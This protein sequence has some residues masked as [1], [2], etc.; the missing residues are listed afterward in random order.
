MAERK[1]FICDY[2]DTYHLRPGHPEESEV[3]AVRRFRRDGNLFGIVFE[4]NTF[5]A[6]ANMGEYEDEYDFIIGSTGAGGIAMLPLDG[7]RRAHT[8][9]FTDTVNQYYACELYDLFVSVG[10][11]VVSVDV[12]GFAGGHSVGDMLRSQ[13][14]PA[15]GQGCYVQYWAGGGKYVVCLTNRDGLLLTT[16]FTQFNGTF[17]NHITAEG[18]AA[19]VNRRYHGKLRAY[20]A[21]NDVNVVSVATSKAEAVRRCAEYAGISAENVWTFGNGTE[22]ACMLRE[23]NGIAKSDGHSA[24]LA[25]TQRQAKTV[26]EAIDIIC[27]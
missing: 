17:K 23:F 21:G 3:N 24:V 11:S 6:M 5:L 15:K 22:D 26:E 14:D 8:R 12:L 13:Y 25:A 27:G 19:E 1:L 18:L 16:P 7:D 4:T 2:E 20:A 10:A 9:I